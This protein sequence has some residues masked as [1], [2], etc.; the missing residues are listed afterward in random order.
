MEQRVDK[1]ILFTLS[2]CP[3][4]R[5]MSTVLREVIKI[6]DTIQFET[7]YVDIQTEITNRYRVKKNPTTLFLDKQGN[8]LYRTEEFQETEQVMDFI[9]QINQKTLDVQLSY[10]EN[11]ESVENYTV[12]LFQNES[13]VPIEL[14]YQNKTSVRAPRITAI[15]LLLKTKKEGYE[16]PFPD[17]SVLELVNFKG[18][19]VHIVINMKNEEE[20]QS[21]KDKMRLALIKTLSRFGVEYVELTITPLIPN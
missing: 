6:L 11:K 7:V 8:E 18:N 21:D 3:T 2:A 1:I 12:Y 4:G 14:Q 10:E 17:S 15:Q 5:S 20:Q 13:V 9:R 19:V 16:N